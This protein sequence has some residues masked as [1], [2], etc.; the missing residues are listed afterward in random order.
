MISLQGLLHARTGQTDAA[1]D[2]VMKA[3][4]YPQSFG[5]AHHAYYQIACVHAV[6]GRPE[7]AFAWLERSVNTGF[8]CWPF[9]LK[10]PN[11]ERLRTMPEFE[12]LISSLQ[13][14]YPDHLG[15]L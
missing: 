7:T 8:A 15:L 9:F 2:C 10:D 3:C 5:H 1:M 12:L 13:A 14:K 11:L 4:S 6:I